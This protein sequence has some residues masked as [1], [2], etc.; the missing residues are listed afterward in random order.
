MN[1]TKYE[2]ETI[3]NYNQEDAEATCFTR[4]AKLIRRLDK[5][6]QTSPLI[7][8]TKIGD[9]FKEY[10]LPKKWVKVR[11]PKQMSEENRQKAAERA[12]VNFGK[13]KEEA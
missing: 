8:V 3:I 1:L 2:Q 7:S 4:D 9:G 6:C 11:M 5:L 12:R 13:M 10:T